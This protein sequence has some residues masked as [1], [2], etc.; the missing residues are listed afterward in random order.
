MP[1]RDYFLD[2]FKLKKATI[3]DMKELYQR[4]FRWFETMGYSFYERE[5]REIAEQGGSKHLEIR[6]IATKEIDNYMRFGIEMEFLILG[7]SKVE[8]E[9]G[10]VKIGTNKGTF[11]TRIT[12]YLEKDY[13]GKWSSSPMMK[14]F[15][16]IY[17]RLMIRNRLDRYGDELLKDTGML[18]D[19]IKAFMAMYKY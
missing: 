19:D 2:K 10:G 6:W 5:Y 3:F 9:R 18:V 4:L 7:L 14:T 1:Y 8:I 16:S 12:C 17:E 11:E 13:N 15:R